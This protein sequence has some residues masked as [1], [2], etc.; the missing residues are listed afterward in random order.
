MMN[1]INS[2]SPKYTETQEH[3]DI[4]IMSEVRVLLDGKR[5]S[6]SPSTRSSKHLIYL[7]HSNR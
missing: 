3:I 7:E 6:K 1:L 2:C 4:L 5:V